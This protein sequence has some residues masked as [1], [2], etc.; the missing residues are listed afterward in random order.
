[1]TTPHN[2]EATV[3]VYRHRKT[4]QIMCEYLEGARHLNRSL[5]WDHLAT[6]E[7]RMWIQEHYS[8]V[9]GRQPTCA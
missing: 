9:M 5:D 2:L 1:M 4:K 8:Y 6:L 3:F 7:P